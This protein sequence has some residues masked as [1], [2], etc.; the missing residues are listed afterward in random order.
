MG[1]LLPTGVTLFVVGL[2][3]SHLVLGLTR[4]RVQKDQKLT[5]SHKVLMWGAVGLVVVGLVCG[6]IGALFGDS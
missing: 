4:K 6:V 5:L 1:I 2:L 3:L